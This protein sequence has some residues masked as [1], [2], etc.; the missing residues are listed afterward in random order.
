MKLGRAIL[1]SLMLMPFF[2]EASARYGHKIEVQEALRSELNSVLKAASLLHG[3]CFE[4]NESRIEEQTR[5]VIASL[6]KAA[7]KSALAHMQRTLL[8]KIIEAARSK[9]EMSQNFSGDERK[10][11]LKGAFKD[12]VQMAQAFKLDHYRIFFCKKD[13]SVW[14]QKGSR[15]QN[16]IHPK[17]YGNCGQPWQKW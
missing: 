17:R 8:L 6:D 10:E 3:A 16:P 13:E 7:K 11:S 4:Q 12:I 2:T 15:A 5:A 9:L 14:L 1:F